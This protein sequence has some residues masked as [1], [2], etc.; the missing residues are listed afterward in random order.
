M[1]K[2]L[3]A[4]ISAAAM[5]GLVG[6][7]GASAASIVGSGHDMAATLNGNTGPTAPGSGPLAVGTDEVCIFCHTPHGAT[8][9]E[10]PLWWRLAPATT[11]WTMYDSPSLGMTP[12]AAP[13]GVSLA[14]LSCHDGATALDNL[15]HIGGNTILNADGIT[16]STMADW[17]SWMIIG[18]GG[19]LATEHPISFNYG[20]SVTAK[21]AEIQPLATVQTA[22]LKFFGAGADQM[23]CATCHAVHDP[24]NE[25]FLRLSNAAS[26]L[27]LTCHIK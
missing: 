6:I 15:Q 23:E 12:G 26:A 2:F 17:K 8:S 11:S 27:C 18:D 4:S 5:V 1:R 14:C 7:T 9:T 25:P 16:H 24:A 3:L 19:N 13:Q 22:G 10:V 20:D 21:P